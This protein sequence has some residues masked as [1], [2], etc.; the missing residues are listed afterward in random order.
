MTSTVSEI[1]AEHTIAFSKEVYDDVNKLEVT[2]FF[3]QCY[4]TDNLHC[5][6][7][8]VMCFMP[9]SGG[10]SIIHFMKSIS[11]P[12][13]LLS[14]TQRFWTYWTEVC[15]I[16]STEWMTKILPMCAT[17][18]LQWGSSLSYHSLESSAASNSPTTMPY[19]SL[20]KLLNNTISRPGSVCERE[21]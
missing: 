2:D 21:K 13:D 19:P 3:K 5:G 15:K 10:I 14:G 1:R 8:T 18:Y 9:Q 4:A 6:A 16:Y 20:H 17:I 12:Q 11:L 7:V